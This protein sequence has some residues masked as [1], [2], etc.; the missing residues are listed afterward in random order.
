MH[1]HWRR[2]SNS[3][4]GHFMAA[5]QTELGCGVKLLVAAKPDCTMSILGAWS[6]SV[7]EL[8][9]ADRQTPPGQECSNGSLILFAAVSWRLF[10]QL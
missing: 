5:M 6:G 4:A 1:E 10:S 8:W 7:Q 3:K 2:A 9:I